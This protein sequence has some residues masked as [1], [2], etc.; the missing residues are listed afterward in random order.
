[1]DRYNFIKDA[2]RPLLLNIQ[3]LYK[4]IALLFYRYF[5]R[6]KKSHLRFPLL[7]HCPYSRTK[8]GYILAKIICL[9]MLTTQT[10]TLFIF[11]VMTCDDVIIK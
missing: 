2:D 1:M 9:F 8:Y 4:Y 10:L 11:S 7:P 3:S 6:K 5:V